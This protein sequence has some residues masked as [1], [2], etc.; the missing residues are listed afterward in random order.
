MMEAKAKG[1]SFERPIDVMTT[2][3]SLL[4]LKG[5]FE[6]IFLLGNGMTA[7]MMTDSGGQSEQ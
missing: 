6:S 3:L 4:M 2:T 7:G 5:Y 1:R